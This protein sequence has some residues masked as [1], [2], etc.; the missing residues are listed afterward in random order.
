LPAASIATHAL[1]THPWLAH[2][3]LGLLPSGSA[4]GLYD[5]L[6]DVPGN[7][8]LVGIGCLRRRVDVVHRNVALIAVIIVDLAA[9]TTHAHDR[10][11]LLSGN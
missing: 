8:L 2:A 9:A 11:F 3:W 5:S 4:L 10:C 6:L 7:R 1:L